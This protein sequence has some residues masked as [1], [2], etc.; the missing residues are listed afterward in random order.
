MREGEIK[1]AFLFSQ[2]EQLPLQASF[3]DEGLEINM[4]ELNEPMKVI[5]EAKKII[6]G[7]HT[8][9]VFFFG[10]NFYKNKETFKI[11]SPQILEVYRIFLVET[12]L[13]SMFYYTFEGPPHFS[14]RT[15]GYIM[16]IFPWDRLISRQTDNPW[17]SYSQDL[18]PP[19][20][21]LGV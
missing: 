13:K 11:F 18:N 9:S 20:F 8:M 12:T 1:S 17:P 3:M 10:N 7:D 14:N 5:H 15:L 4:E 16:H 6:R 21:F 2:E 19:E